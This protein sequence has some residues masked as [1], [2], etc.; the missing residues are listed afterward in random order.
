MKAAE[1]RDLSHDE[2]VRRLDELKE[3][4]FNLRFQRASGQLEDTNRLRIIRREIARVMTIIGERQRE[5]AAEAK[6]D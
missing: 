3:E 5:E 2:L 6:N 1:M 4:Q